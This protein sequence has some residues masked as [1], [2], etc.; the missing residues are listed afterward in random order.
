[1]PAMDRPAP[2]PRAGHAALLLNRRGDLLTP[3]TRYALLPGLMGVCMWLQLRAIIDHDPA[4]IIHGTEIFLNGGTLYQDIFEINPPLIFYLTVPPVWLARM[5]GV[6]DV[7]VFILYVFFLMAISLAIISVLLRGGDAFSRHDGNGLVLAAAVAMEV[8]PA[9][10]FG[11]REHL[12]LILSLPYVCLVI[13]RSRSMPTGM[14]MPIGIGVLAA[15]GF[16]LKPHFLL[17]PAALECYLI[18]RTGNFWRRIRPG[19]RPETLVLAGMVGLYFLVI[20]YF[21]PD[22]LTIIVPLALALYGRGY[23]VSLPEVLARPESILLPT[24]VWMHLVCRRRQLVPEIGDIFIIASICFFVIYVVQM[25]GWPYQIYPLDATLF[26]AVSSSLL[27]SFPLHEPVRRIR[28]LT[29]AIGLLFVAMTASAVADQ[30]KNSI[31]TNRFMTDAAP[32]VRG[33]PPGSYIYVFS[34]AVSDGFPLV[35]YDR[36]GWSSRFDTFWWLPG[37]ISLPSPPAVVERFL[38][39]AVVEDLKKNRPALIFVDVAPKRYRFEDRDFDY[40]RFFSV[41]PRFRAILADYAEAAVVDNVLVLRR[42]SGGS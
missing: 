26:M 33:L 42:R 32:F 38:R 14:L 11:Q 29:A 27:G 3:I 35:N 25:K 4:L 34:A 40:L 7:N 2:R 39:D 19:I 5:L 1:M 16:A 37:L 21:T 12:M 28:V 6:F 13:M 18:K 22:Y 9:E 30:Y 41:D 23:D 36:L 20:L 31:R 10:R 8:L 24:V 15:L 17:V